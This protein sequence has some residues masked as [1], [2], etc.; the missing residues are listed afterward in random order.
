MLAA[1]DETPAGSALFYTIGGPHYEELID[2]QGNSPVKSGRGGDGSA[3]NPYYKGGI[4]FRS[5]LAAAGHAAAV[6]IDR[7]KG[8]KPYGVL[9]EEADVEWAADQLAGSL[10]HDRPFVRVDAY[11]KRLK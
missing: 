5:F 6:S 4:I 11:D 2:R 9:A 7:D 1:Y 3:E 8:Y 10:L